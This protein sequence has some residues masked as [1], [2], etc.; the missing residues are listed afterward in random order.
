MQREGGI[1]KVKALRIFTLV[2]DPGVNSSIPVAWL[3]LAI[4]EA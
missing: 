3:V 4:A 2:G 1:R